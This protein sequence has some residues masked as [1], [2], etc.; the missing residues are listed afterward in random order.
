MNV[1][2]R[3]LRFGRKAVFLGVRT[4]LSLVALALSPIGVNPLTLAVVCALGIP[5][6]LSLLAIYALI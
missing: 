1:L 4:V 6:F 2:L 3:C 5:G